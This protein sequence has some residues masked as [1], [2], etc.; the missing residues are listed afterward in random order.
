MKKEGASEEQ[1]AFEQSHYW[2]ARAQGFK[3]QRTLSLTFIINLG[4]KG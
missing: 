3:S 1:V 2:I 4:V